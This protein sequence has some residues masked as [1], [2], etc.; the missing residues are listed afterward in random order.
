MELAL[1]LKKLQEKVAKKHDYDEKCIVGIMLARYDI[2]LTRSIINDCYEYWHYNTGEHFDIFWAGYGR[3]LP[4]EKQTKSKIIMDFP[5][6][7]D[8]AYFDSQSFIS[9]K[10]ALNDE[11]KK[12]YKDHIQLILVNC[13]NGKLQFNAALQIDLEENI[14]PNYSTIRELMEWITNETRSQH[15]VVSLA[16]ELKSKKM[17]EKIK[18]ISFTETVNIA[19]GALSLAF[20][21]LPV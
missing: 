12:N 18:G 16:S 17:F 3:Y 11:L 14:D 1:T 10:N 8:H 9:I 13:E 4:F 6:N 20:S 2:S 19:L 21:H 15:D 7:D 5:G